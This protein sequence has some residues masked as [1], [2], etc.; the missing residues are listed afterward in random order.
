MSTF[1]PADFLLG[2][3]LAGMSLAQLRRVHRALSTTSDE[4]R[5]R[6]GD[7]ADTYCA[8]KAGA[9]ALIAAEIHRRGKKVPS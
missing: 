6:L 5:R 3:L 9:A 8:Q 4:F 1:D 7:R 2:Y